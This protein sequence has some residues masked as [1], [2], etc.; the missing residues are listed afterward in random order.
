MSF[1]QLN[2]EQLL[3][4][5]R[6]FEI[7]ADENAKNQELKALLNADPKANF[8]TYKRLLDPDPVEE[9]ENIV[10]NDMVILK[11]SRENPS[12]EAFG[13]RFTKDNPYIAMSSDQAQLIINS[14]D[15]FLI[16]SPDEV[17]SYYS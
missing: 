16:A 4:A 5:C 10:Y 15:G 3:D 1:S 2:K 8:Q 17:K 9:P 13:F 14:Y 7:D 11:M 6:L 12:F